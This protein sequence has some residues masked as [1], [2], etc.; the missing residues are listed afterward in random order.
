MCQE[1]VKLIPFC[2]K[3]IALTL[4]GCLVDRRAPSY[5]TW[6]Y[7]MVFLWFMGS[8]TKWPFNLCVEVWHLWWGQKGPVPWVWLLLLHYWISQWTWWSVP[9]E[10]NGISPPDRY[11]PVLKITPGFRITVQNFLKLQQ[12]PGW[13]RHGGGNLLLT[14]TLCLWPPFTKSKWWPCRCLNGNIRF[15]IPHAVNIPKMGNG[16]FGKREKTVT[17][18]IMS[19][20]TRMT[21]AKDVMFSPVC[22][23]LHGLPHIWWACWL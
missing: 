8:D 22:P 7:L 3:G 9:M 11:I 17:P 1:L 2:I 21:S 10:L 4:Y 20:K 12:R 14:W 13:F 23:S 19:G 5:S 16:I 18:T 6:L 15:W